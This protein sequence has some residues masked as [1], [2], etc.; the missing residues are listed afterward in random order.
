MSADD[1]RIVLISRLSRFIDI[2][3]NTYL[4]IDVNRNLLLMKMNEY[5]S[6]I[7]ELKNVR[8][9]INLIYNDI[10]NVMNAKIKK[11]FDQIVKQVQKLNM[12]L[13]NI[14]KKWGTRRFDDFLIC[15][16]RSLKH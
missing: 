3:Q 8:K 10:Q 12:E 14:L 6:C 4:H 15:R 1:V 7:I 2:V 5:K 11:S 16:K 9:T 13:S